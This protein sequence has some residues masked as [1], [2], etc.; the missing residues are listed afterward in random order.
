MRNEDHEMCSILLDSGA[1]ASVFPL[2]I[3]GSGVRSHQGRSNLQDAQGRSIPILDMPDMRDVEIHLVDERGKHVLLRETV[4]V[5]DQISQ[6]ILCSGKLLESG[7]G[8]NGV[9]Q[10]LVHNSGISVPIELQNRSMSVRGWIRMLKHELNVEPHEGDDD[11]DVSKDSSLVRAVK[12]DVF[13]GLT[14]LRVGWRL[15][16]DGIGTGKHFGNTFQ[17]P[18]LVMP[19]MTGEKFRTT[20]VE[21]DNQWICLE[22]CERMSDIVDL[23]AEFFGYIGNRYVITVIT[24]SERPPQTM[25]FSLLV[26]ED[27][28]ETNAPSG[29]GVEMDIAPI[30]ED[31]EIQGIDIDDSAQQRELPYP[32]GQVIHGQAKDDCILVNGIEVFSHSSLATLR[33]AFGFYN[34]AKSGSKSKCF[35][36]P[37]EFQKQLELHAVMGAARDAEAQDQREPKPQKLAKV[38]YEMEQMKHR[39]THLPF[40]PWCEACT[41]H[42]SKQDHRMRSGTSRDSG[43]ATISFD[44]CYTKAGGQQQQA[45]DLDAVCALVMI[46]SN[47][48]FMG[49][50]PVSGKGQFAMMVRE[51][52]NFTQISGHAEVICRCDN[53]PTLKQLQSLVV[54]AQQQ[55]GLPTR[56]TA[57]V[58]YSHGNSLCEN[59]IQRIRDLAGSLMHTVQQKLNTVISSEHGLWSWAMRHAAWLL[60]RFSPTQSVTPFEL[61]YNK[62]YKGK[63]CQFA[64]P[65]FGF[66]KTALKGNPKRMRMLFLGKVEGQDSF[67]LYN[68][69]HVMLSRS[70]RRIDSDWKEYLGF[71]MHFHAPTWDFKT[72]YGGRIVSTK[73]KLEAQTVSFT[74]PLGDVEPSK[75]HDAEA[76]AVRLKAREEQREESEIAAMGQ[77]DPLF[78]K[79]LTPFEIPETGG[80][81]VLSQQDDAESSGA[82]IMYSDYVPTTPAK[83]DDGQDN[84]AEQMM[85]PTTPRQAAATRS[86]D[87]QP[88]EHDAKKARVEEHKK[89]RIN[90]LREVQETRIR[91]VQIADDTFFTLDEYEHEPNLED[92]ADE[93]EFWEGED[94]LQ[95]GDVPADLW[96]DGPIDQTPPEPPEWVDHL[97]DEVELKR[98]IDMKVIEPLSSYDGEVEGSLTAKHVYDW[99]LKQFEGMVDGKMVSTKRWMRRSRLVA[100]EFNNSKR[101]D[102]YSPATG[103]HTSNLIPLIYLQRMVEVMERGFSAE[104]EYDTLMASLDIKD[105]FLQ[106]PQ[107]HVV[108]VTLGSKQFAVLRNLPG[109]RIGA[110]AWYWHFRKF[111]TEKLNFIWNVEQPCLAKCGTNV[112]MMHVDDLLFVGDRKYWKETF[113]PALEA[114]FKISRNELGGIGTSIS[115]LKRKIEQLSDGL[116]IAPGTSV[117]SV[118]SNFEKCFG[119]ARSQKVPCDAAIQQQ[120]MSSMLSA[121]DSKNYRSVVGQLLYLSRDRPDLMFGVKELA[122][123][124]AKPTVCSVQRL[125]K[126]VG[127]LKQKGDIG[128]K[129]QVPEAG[130]GKIKQG[131]SKFWLL[132]SFSDADWSANKTT[133]RS[134]SCGIHFLNGNYVYGS[135]RSQKV[136]SLSS[137]ESELHA[138]VSCCCDGIYIKRCMEFLVCQTVDQVQFTDNSA[139]RQLASRQGVGRVRHLAGKLL[140]IQEWLRQEEFE[141]SQVGTQNNYSDVA[142][143]PLKRER[144]ECLLNGIGAIYPGDQQMVG[145]EE[146]DRIEEVTVQKSL[147]KRMAKFVMRMGF[148]WGLEPVRAEGFKT[149]DSE[150]CLQDEVPNEI[151]LKDNYAWFWIGI[152]IC[153]AVVAWVTFGMAAWRVLQKVRRDLETCWNQVAD[154][155][156]FGSN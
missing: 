47:T 136:V 36:R 126:L 128:L 104:T 72:G 142:T 21:V 31:D 99:R 133:R 82:E 123:A 41:A 85:V 22:L 98:L 70:I 114:E 75:L 94:Q 120:D 149:S 40:Q 18:S 113:I 115:F 63:L 8:V 83:S 30:A 35:Q 141:L 17:D 2:S 146:H 155:D 152:F 44:L 77:E 51:I 91:S 143:K 119:P 108:S 28:K 42:R 129:M 93:S 4:A 122:S 109:Q 64:E 92:D 134:T 11:G 81:P 25:G 88:E 67:I 45:R 156:F 148:A 135:S 103:C 53:E 121:R 3:S 101:L 27:V 131:G 24:E 59:A 90:V 76:E 144:M 37:W 112:F 84:A 125:R 26:D 105:A 55:M 61:V 66:T 96:Y 19:N 49:C 117:E 140:W 153:L 78:N 32:A 15:N 58:A 124:M 34:L 29:S 100:R 107:E 10:T 151:E 139:A 14:E 154:E 52:V 39:L 60:N 95:F 86:H 54:K 130:K 48:G 127:Y 12:A 57:P 138:M 110:K 74:K 13:G 6:P 23:S 89:Q 80:A 33:A 20:L 116:M 87:D 71:F 38:P 50:V 111:A 62:T 147:L 46:D 79:D 16:S 69:S 7:W 5:S 9:E 150:I 97:A 106:V 102:T 145:Q 68:G 65:V 43:I 132:E 56:K 137:C 118:V 73:T 1:D